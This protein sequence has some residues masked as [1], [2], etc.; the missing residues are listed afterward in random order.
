V[1]VSEP[2]STLSQPLVRACHHW[3]MST[4]R[5]QAAPAVSQPA[6][7]VPM[8]RAETLKDLLGQTHRGTVPIRTVFVQQGRGKQTKPGPLATFNSAHD[9]RGLDAYLFVHALASSAPWDCDYPSGTWIRAFGLTDTATMVSA[10]GVISKILR[11]L[12]TRKL[13]RRGRSGRRAVVTLLKEDGS[14][15]P[16]ER[17]VAKND[18][19][20]HLPYEYWIEG[21]YKLLSLPAKTMLLVALSL[22]DNFYLPLEKAPRWYGVSADSAGRGLRE[23]QAHGFLESSTQWI[24]NH[25]SDTGWTEQ[26]LYKLVGPYSTESRKKAS[27]AHVNRG[28]TDPVAGEDVAAP[29]AA[30][31]VGDVA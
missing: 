18:N 12:E 16:Y 27:R 14:A 20:F 15:E 22:Q 13:I 23:L 7:P 19:W 8:T 25:R 17:P 2:A 11:R 21:H 31:P 24:K 29:P 4:T 1:P 6:Q 28:V 9:D 3:V 5:D 26:R 30:H 10:R